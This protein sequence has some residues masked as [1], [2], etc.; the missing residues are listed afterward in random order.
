LRTPPA[1]FDELSEAM[2]RV[3]KVRI[4]QLSGAKIEKGNP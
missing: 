4:V 3:A 2:G 1:E